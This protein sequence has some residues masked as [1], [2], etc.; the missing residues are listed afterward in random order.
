MTCC[1]P[2]EP[3]PAVGECPDCGEPVDE[4]GYIAI[5]NCSYSPL[6]CDTCGWRPCD[7]SC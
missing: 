4:D 3:E 2:T 1:D 5:P 6:E 7:Q